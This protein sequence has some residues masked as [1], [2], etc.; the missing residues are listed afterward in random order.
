MDLSYEAVSG[1][2]LA[3]VRRAV[4]NFTGKIKQPIKLEI[5]AV[6]V[7]FGCYWIF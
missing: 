3:T 4:N 1:L 5:L 6:I 7:G 2:S